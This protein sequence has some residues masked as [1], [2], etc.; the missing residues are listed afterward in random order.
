MQFTALLLWTA[1]FFAAFA[2]RLHKQ[3]LGEYLAEGAP[4]TAAPA[5]APSKLRL[6]GLAAAPVLNQQR[7]TDNY[8]LLS[9]TITAC[10]RK[11][12]V[13]L[14][15]NSGQIVAM[16][17]PLLFIFIFAKR[18]LAHYPQYLLPGAIGYTMLGLLAALYNV[19]GAD[20]AGVQ[21]YLLA[22]VRLRDVI[23]AKNLASLAL[24]T[25]EAALA[26]C[27][28]SLLATAPIPLANQ[29]STLFWVV[30]MLFAN[31]AFG[32]LR[33]IQAPRKIAIAQARR[34]RSPSADKTTGLLVLAILF[35]SFL[36]QIPVTLLC[37]HFH[38]PWLGAVIFAPLAAVAVAAYIL[39]LAN[40]DRLILTHRDTFAQDLCSD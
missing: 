39:L 4:R 5:G 36:L 20:G 33:S 7:T 24:L 27:A 1:A 35:G 11:E 18:G 30:F 16:L 15:G 14:R 3:F 22:P 13:Y 10:L 6:G 37:R 17:M 40:A 21:L 12:W 19:F 28:V 32:T 9:P 8:Q 29:I 34:M 31:L 25:I 2:L 38:N 23:L 26:W